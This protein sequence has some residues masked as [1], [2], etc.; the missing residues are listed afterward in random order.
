MVYRAEVMD[1]Q[2]KIHTVFSP[3]SWKPRPNEG[4]LARPIGELLIDNYGR[5]RIKPLYENYHEPH[6]SPE[7]AETVYFVS[8]TPLGASVS[9]PD[10]IAYAVAQSELM[11]SL[12]GFDKESLSHINGEELQDL[13][14][15]ARLAYR[16]HAGIHSM[17]NLRDR[18]SL[19]R[20]INK[21][22][23]HRDKSTRLY[24]RRLIANMGEEEIFYQM[25]EGIIDGTLVEVIEE[26]NDIYYKSD[27]PWFKPARIHA[28][29]SLIDLAAYSS[30]AKF[31]ARQIGQRELR[32]QLVEQQINF[33]SQIQKVAGWGEEYV[34]NIRDYSKTINK[35]SDLQQYIARK[36]GTIGSAIG[37]LTEGIFLGVKRDI[38]LDDGRFKDGWERQAFIREDN[39]TSRDQVAI[40]MQ[41]D[42]ND[43][44][45]IPNMTFDLAGFDINVGDTTVRTEVK[46]H[47]C[48]S[49][50][51]MMPGIEVVSLRDSSSMYDF[52]SRT[53][54]FALE[55]IGHYTG[56]DVGSEAREA[57]KETIRLI[58]IDAKT[59]EDNK[60]SR[61]GT[62]VVRLA[63]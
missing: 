61:Y 1:N 54:N 44:L 21:L 49:A 50:T 24:R 20:A 30:Y 34:K 46:K 60:A 33:Y 5:G 6:L 18:L 62:A 27:L 36:A 35:Q 13:A 63:V 10:L 57:Y 32:A 42:E 43:S 31:I 8:T 38:R 3:E 12:D 11:G 56:G 48:P 23:I 15:K 47:A 17:K 2:R 51:S 14:R 58:E 37:A 39:M 25:F 52:F 22:D 4:P 59:R 41:L 53:R 9:K 29:F 55:R 40:K 28:G 45:S 26:N 19:F 16:A 7:W